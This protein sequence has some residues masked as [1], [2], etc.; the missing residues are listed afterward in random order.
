MLR[1][2][3]KIGHGAFQGGDY[4]QVGGE[5]VFENEEVTWCH[6][7]RNTRDHAELEEVRQVLGLPRPRPRQQP[8]R[9]AGSKRWSATF[10]AGR[11][12]GRNLSQKRASWVFG[13][14]KEG[15]ESIDAGTPTEYMGKTKL[16]VTEE[17]DNMSL[18]L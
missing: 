6:R 2:M 11:A 10:G 12:L 15:R 8:I 13:G 1:N 9:R 18:P 7:M 4:R 16:A 17:L 14:K 5:F 3:T